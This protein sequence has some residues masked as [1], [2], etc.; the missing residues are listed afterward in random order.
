MLNKPNSY[1][2][3]IHTILTIGII[4]VWLIN[5]LFCKL[6]NLVPRHQ[7][8]VARI[9]GEEHADIFTK[10]IGIAEILM[11]VW[12]ITG[13]KSRI[14]AIVQIIVVATMNTIEFFLAPDL[15]LFGRG[16]ILMA[17]LLIILIYMNEFVVYCSEHRVK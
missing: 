17:A 9:L 16:N 8:I 6:L 11:C 13:I 14:C 5:G 4:L 7:Q 3:S 10:A 15:L 2:S 1:K 12:I